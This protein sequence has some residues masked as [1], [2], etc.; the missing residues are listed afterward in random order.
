MFK[1][2]HQ[3]LLETSHKRHFHCYRQ[4][5]FARQHYV[6]VGMPHVEF[7]LQ[8]YLPRRW[9]GT[10]RESKFVRANILSQSVQY[11][12]AR[13]PVYGCSR[14]DNKACPILF[15][16]HGAGVDADGGPWLASYQQQNYSWTLLPT[17]RGIYG[18]DWQ[19][20]GESKLKPLKSG[21]NL[22]KVVWMLWRHA[23]TSLKLCLVSPLLYKARTE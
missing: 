5:L 1:C 18:F 8:I 23:I 4:Q 7:G 16:L 21:A 12:V 20:A 10:Q 2:D 3:Q 9:S 15:S 6:L 17:N 13:P 11:A 14:F 22:L 19:G